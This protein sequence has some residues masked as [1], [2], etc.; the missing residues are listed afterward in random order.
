M[1]PSRECHNQGQRCLSMIF[2]AENF[3]PFFNDVIAK[4][5]HIY[6]R[7]HAKEAKF[8]PNAFSSIPPIAIADLN[9]GD[10]ITIRAFFA[11][12]KSLRPRVDSGYLDLEVEYVDLDSNSVFANIITDLPTAFSLAKGTTIELD[13]DEVLYKPSR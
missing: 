9:P 4:G 8:Y 12:G 7:K 1:A 10:R 5:F 2:D 11:I 3:T 13:I 6:S